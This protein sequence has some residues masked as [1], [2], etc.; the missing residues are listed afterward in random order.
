M[1]AARQNVLEII[2]DFEL[3]KRYRRKGIKLVVEFVN[4]TST[5]SNRENATLQC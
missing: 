3:I 1:A 4:N 2:E 5:F